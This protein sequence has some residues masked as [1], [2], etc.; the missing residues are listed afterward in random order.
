MA[1]SIESPYATE[2]AY[3]WYKNGSL[4]P[5]ATGA[6]YTT[7]ATS[8]AADNGA[9]YKVSV[10]VPGA[11]KTS[12][13]ATLTVAA[14]TVAP[15]ITKVKAS[16]VQNLIVTFDEPLDKA[17][18]ETVGNYSISDGVTISTATASD[19]AVLLATSGLTVD[20]SYVLTAGGVKDPFNNALAANTTFPFTAN[21][22]TYADVILED[23][24]IGFYRFEETTGQK[25]KNFGTAG[26]TADGLYMLGSGPDDSAPTDVASGEGPRPG[27]FLGFDPNNRSVLMDGANTTLWID[28]Q[29][30]FLNNLAAFSLEYWVKPANRVS[31]P[32]AFGTRIGLVGQND[33]VEYGFINQTTVQ[34]WSAGG[35]S[36]DTAYTFPDGEWHHIATIADGKSIKNYYDGVLVGTGGTTTANYG[37][38]TFNVHIGGGG[39]YD[40]T[41][42]FFSGQFDEVAIFDK[43]I[44]ADRIAAHFKAG[45][46]GG[47][48]PEPVGEA[49]FTQI[50]F[51]GGQVTMQ[52]EGT[53]TLEEATQIT[54]PWTTSANQTSPQT[55]APTGANKF[56]RLRQ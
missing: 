14:D 41:G 31:D 46:E 43:A 4:I 42:N 35:G 40:A 39:V 28:T 50:S 6:T 16:S 1:A 13:E 47:E 51:A 27:E 12:D 18:A 2:P 26:E 3:Q 9:K 52:W 20:K 7:P 55:V 10:S 33:A 11:T 8:L 49:R 54:G 21:V 53:A 23:K 44:P 36:L 30:Q 56:F 29:K 37:S 48:A 25:T 32:A 5:S 45:K 22:I 38:S 34:I 15:K 17:S 19:N 24:P